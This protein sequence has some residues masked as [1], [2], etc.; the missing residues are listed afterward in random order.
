M[1]DVP[2]DIYAFIKQEIGRNPDTWGG[3]L[4]NNWDLTEAALSGKTV[5]VVAGGSLSLTATER[6]NKFHDISGILSSNQIIVVDNFVHVWAV[7]NTT[8][9]A[10]TLSYK[11]VT[12]AATVIPQGGTTWV[13]CDG[14]NVIVVGPST[15][16]LT[17]QLL[18]PS[19]TLAAPGLAFAAEL[20]T[21]WH[22]ALANRIVFGIAGVEKIAID[23][24][25]YTLSLATGGVYKININ[26]VEV[27]K[28]DATNGL[29][30]S[31]IKL[32]G[33]YIVPVGTIV[34][35]G[36]ITAPN[37]WLLCDGDAYSQTTYSEL[38]NAISTRFGTGGGATFRVPD[39]RG[40]VLA[41]DDGMGPDPP[42]GRLT[43]RPGGVAGTIGSVGGDEEHLL[44]LAQMPQHNHAVGSLVISGTSGGHGHDIPA[45]QFTADT[46]G[47]SFPGRLSAASTHEDA[48]DYTF[49]GMLDTGGTHGHTITGSVANTPAAV[50]AAHNNV[51]PTLV[52]YYMIFSAV[53]T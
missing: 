10:F 17:N 46:E 6:R 13:L 49:T 18:A 43:G 22:R 36:R 2:T 53:F 39:L 4:N 1:A 21:G 29:D 9:G 19:G 44:V 48:D 20:N 12:G 3:I 28:V 41:G 24:N 35:T 33:E 47:S 40:R 45:R 23:P 32:N 30:A 52:A 26:N 5:K 16:L 15:R 51:Q 8:S 25:E 27:L 14:S 11:T 7:R 38:F 42:I 50:A 34:G 37:G 31:K